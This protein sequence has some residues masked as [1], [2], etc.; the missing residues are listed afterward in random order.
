MQQALHRSYLVPRGFVVETAYYEGDSCG[1]GVRKRRP[2][3]IVRNGF[4][5]CLEPLSTPRDRSAALGADRPA[6]GNRPPIPLQCRPMRAPNLHRALRRRRT[7]AIGATHGKAGLHRL[8]HRSGAWRS[9]GS[10]LCK[11]ANAAGEQ[12]YASSGS[13]TP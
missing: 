10:R 1:S 3:S 4:P 13:S 7:G 2:V 12:R 5:T 9:I 11:A 8:S 6:L